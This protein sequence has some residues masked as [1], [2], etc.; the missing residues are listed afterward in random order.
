MELK[1]INQA[2]VIGLIA[3][4]L[5]FFGIFFF[6]RSPSFSSLVIPLVIIGAPLPMWAAS[7]LYV[8]SVESSRAVYYSV[9]FSL[10]FLIVQFILDGI[11][12]F[13][14][15]FLNKPPLSDISIKSLFQSLLIAYFYIATIPLLEA[16]RRGRHGQ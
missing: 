2:V 10:I 11:F 8:K 1:K 9:I 3:W 6:Y 13:S 5:G 12:A 16:R 14:I 15:F 7:Y 4:L